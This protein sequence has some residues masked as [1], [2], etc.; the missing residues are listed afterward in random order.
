MSSQPTAQQKAQSAA[1]G[2]INHPV[3]AGA[4]D[5][6]NQQLSYLGASSPS[7]RSPPEKKGLDSTALE[8]IACWC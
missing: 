7:P 3:V 8:P 6:V 4:R 2:L 1:Q 5:S